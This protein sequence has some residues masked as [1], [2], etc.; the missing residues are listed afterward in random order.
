MEDIPL[1]LVFVFL[2]I[3]DAIRVRVVSKWA[4]ESVT[5]FQWLSMLPVFNVWKWRVCFPEAKA[6]WYQGAAPLLYVPRRITHL[7]LEGVRVRECF[8][9]AR[10][11]SVRLLHCYGISP[12]CFTSALVTADFS[13]S[14][15][16]SW[17]LALL[18]SVK[19]LT[20]K[21]CKVRCK[22]I[23]TLVNLT[24]LDVSFTRIE[25]I[26][27]LPNLKLLHADSCPFID[28]FANLSGYALSYLCA[29]NISYIRGLPTG[30]TRV[31]LSG[32]DGDDMIL[33]ALHGVKYV[34]LSYTKFHRYTPLQGASSIYARGAC[35]GGLRDLHELDFL[36]ISE[37]SAVDPS[38]FS[39]IKCI[40]ELVAR[41][42][43]WIDNWAL[44]WVKEVHVLTV[45]CPLLSFSGHFRQM[46]I[47]LKVKTLIACECLQERLQGPYEMRLCGCAKKPFVNT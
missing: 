28:T 12:R 20:V 16:P 2:H 6:L 24:S 3:E 21:A 46:C 19:S 37:C 32:S 10:L 35:I 27:E 47:R 25:H 5:E 26:P 1:H 43:D 36:D 44:R 40:K 41:N 39:N 45:T 31:C 4:L 30:L 13:G 14:R 18:V 17:A 29:S 42:C 8:F 33:E 38:V 15:F 11:T 9:R 34:D 23:G 22:D 7:R